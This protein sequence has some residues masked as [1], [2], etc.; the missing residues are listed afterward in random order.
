MLKRV[1][2][3]YHA[4]VVE[5]TYS[6]LR[7]GSADAQPSHH[8]CAH[9][10]SGFSSLHELLVRRLHPTGLKSTP[11]SSHRS[12]ECTADK[13]TIVI[14]LPFGDLTF[15]QSIE[16][17][18]INACQS[19]SRWLWSLQHPI[20]KQIAWTSTLDRFR[21]ALTYAPHSSESSST[22][23]LMTPPKK[24]PLCHLGLPPATYYINSVKS[25]T[26]ITAAKLIELSSGLVVVNPSIVARGPGFE[27]R[28]DPILLHLFVPPGGAA[29]LLFAPRA[30]TFARDG[31]KRASSLFR[32]A[33]DATLHNNTTAHV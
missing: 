4:D 21:G 17:F 32:S 22:A 30:S 29:R 15:G 24:I 12:A 9:S 31:W 25:M 26:A 6:G 14:A 27:Y 2:S 3:E 7:I 20:A 1:S 10:R 28:R 11:L 5:A 19:E 13:V 18:A 23:C 33:R 8:S 16:V